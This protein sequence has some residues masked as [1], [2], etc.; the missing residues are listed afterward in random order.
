MAVAVLVHAK[1]EQAR[2]FHEQV[3]FESSP[4][5]PLQLMLLMKDVRKV[6]K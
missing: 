1:D 2:T 3:G 5:D 4:I 6:I